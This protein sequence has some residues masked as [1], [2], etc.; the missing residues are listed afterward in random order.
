MRKSPG[1]TQGS[2]GAKTQGRIPDAMV[3]FLATVVLVIGAVGCYDT[4]ANPAAASGNKSQHPSLMHPLPEPFGG[5]EVVRFVLIGSDTRPHD[6]GRADT[7]M[8]LFIAPRLH[9]AV[10]ISI[11]RDLRVPIPG[12]GVD[13]IN[14]SYAYGGPEL[15]RRTVE[16][17]LGVEIPFYVRCDFDTFVKAVDIL[18]GVD[19][20]VPDVEGRGRGM[21]YDDNWGNLH[22]HLK[23]GWHHLNGYEAMGFVRYRHGDSDLMRT[24]RQ[25]QFIRAVIEQKV[26]VANLPA[27][28]RAGSYVLRRLDTNVSWRDAVDMLRVAKTMTATDLMTETVPVRDARIG[29]V[30]YAELLEDKFQKL[31]EQAEAH[32]SGAMVN[33]PPVVVLNGSGI[34][35]AASIAAKRLESLGWV[36]ARTGNAERMDLLHCRVEY[37][38]GTREIAEKLALDLGERNVEVVRSELGLAEIRVIIGQ[39]YSA[40]AVNEGG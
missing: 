3:A 5:A 40:H 29:G 28:L 33:Q 30:Y 12:H 34:Q 1:S 23:P 32:L 19:I 31:M 6:K 8:V 7:T 2:R 20:E 27:L 38:E 26:K 10:L 36:I 25:Q 15:T 16:A 37:P 17:L 39:D 11:P 22:I 4:I 35:G 24:R 18:G 13:K 14:H 9:R 21:N